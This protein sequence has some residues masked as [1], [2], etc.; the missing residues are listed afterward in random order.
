MTTVGYGDVSPTSAYG[1]LV[2][3]LC[4][5]AGL[6]ILALPVS[7]IGSN[8][9]L[10]YSYAQ[11]RLRLPKRTSPALLL[12]DKALMNG[13]QEQA[14]PDDILGKYQNQFAIFLKYLFVLMHKNYRL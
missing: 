3:S 11:A 6:L 12:A 5:C 10:Y 9:A 7:V 4:A 2:G 8:F 14:L 13:T 1:K